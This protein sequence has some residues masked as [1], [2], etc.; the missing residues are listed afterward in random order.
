M[1][2]LIFRT[3]TDDQ[4]IEE[5]INKVENYSG[6]RLP[7]AYAKRNKVVGAFLHEQL[8]AGYMIVTKPDF[9][10]LMFV[11]DELKSTSQIGDLDS[12]DMMEVNGLWL[13]PAVKTPMMQAKVWFNLIKDIFLAKKN[14]VLL[15]QDS[16]N[17]NMERFLSMA[18]PTMLY[19]GPPMLMAGDDSHKSINVGYTT[20]WSIV[21]NTPKYIAEF[22]SR[23]KRADEFEKSRKFD[24]VLDAA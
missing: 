15:M 4:G 11:P 6:V 22:R 3:I 19:S 1:N 10:S 21:L 7:L 14:Y 8:V 13:G 5:V 23:M 18:N 12:Y 2:K 17:K 20:R 24:G 16:R 9:R